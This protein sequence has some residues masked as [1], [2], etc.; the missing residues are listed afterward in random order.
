VRAQT[1]ALPIVTAGPF[2]VRA[3]TTALS[4]SQLELSA[5]VPG[6]I[7]IENEAT[8]AAKVSARMS[9]T[10][11]DVR[12]VPGTPATVHV[13]S[14][15]DSGTV[16]PITV[17]VSAADPWS[18]LAA[19]AIPPIDAHVSARNVST[20]MI[21]ALA[22]EPER[23]PGAIGRALD[24][25][26]DAV[27]ANLEGGTL[28]VNVTG[29]D[30][31]PR[32]VLE[33]GARIE[34]GLVHIDG[35]NAV[36]MRWSPDELWLQR[37]IAALLAPG[38]KLVPD[39]GSELVS[40]EAKNVVVPLPVEG[41]DLKAS[42]RASTAADVTVR[43]SGATW[44]DDALRAAHTEVAVRALETTVKLSA[45]GAFTASV[46]GE[47]HQGPSKGR[48]SAD[49]STSDAWAFA[50]GP[51]VAMP[52]VDAR[53]LADGI[54]TALVD[55]FAHQDG[56]VAKVIGDKLSVSLD[57]KGASPTSGTL[58]AEL[59][60]P[61]A[62]A[63]FS[64]H[65]ET[66]SFRASGTDGL[67]V[68]V[69]VPEA[70]V[71]EQLAGKLPEG[72]S[73]KWPQGA[74]E[75][76]FDANDLSVPVPKPGA[77]P[78][79]L[80]A[81]LESTGAHMHAQLSAVGVENAMT[82]DAKLDVGARELTFDA[83]LS[84]HAPVDVKVA[85]K[86]DPGRDARLDLAARVV[87]PF[88][89]LKGAE[90]KPID[91]T[92]TLTGLDTAALDVLAGKQGLL[93][94]L[95][96]PSLDVSLSANGAS[97]AG[98]SM[99]MN[100]KSESL[101]VKGSAQF[102]K[103]T[104]RC[105]GKDGLDVALTPRPGSLDAYAKTVL[106]AGTRLQFA[107]DA[108]PLT[109]KLHDVSI[110]L[111][112]GAAPS[113]ST[114]AAGTPT[115]A[116]AAETSMLERVSKMSLTCEATMPAIVY[117][118]ASEQPV[119]V[120]NV[121]VEARLSPTEPPYLRVNGAVEATPPGVI[122]VDV[123]ALDPLAKLADPSALDTWRAKVDVR[124][125]QVPTA[126]VD[127]LAG[128]GGLLVEALGAHVDAMVQAPEISLSKGAFVVDLKSEQDSLH[129]EGHLADRAVII[130]KQDGVLA[131]VGLGPLMS[132]R[133]VG[134]LLPTLVDVQKP[135]DAAPAMFAVDALHFPLDGDLR[136]LD[137]NVRIDLG[138]ITYG[139]GNLKSGFAGK[140]ASALG[141]SMPT[142]T[143]K[144]PAITVP[145][146][147]G[148]AGYDKLPIQIGGHEYMFSG[149]YDMV[150]DVALLSA[151][152]PVKLLGKKISAELDRVRDYVDPDITVPITIKG[153]ILNPSIGLDN[154][155]LEKVLKKAAE[156]AVG[157]GLDG[158][159]D[160]L[161]KKKKD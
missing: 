107:A 16:G 35:E 78:F 80:A 88:G 36:R 141:S 62:T 156:K 47:L 11:I 127:L 121:R 153:S 149:T 30:V 122:A 63:S 114:P 54:P 138:V 58:R 145:I 7:G 79:D 113:S 64:G 75:L 68:V 13:E 134:K 95:L 85:A 33:A 34:A 57:A 46:R 101:T 84:P 103:G 99:T 72:T 70:V 161:K 45:G 67:H 51:S 90:L 77:Q 61:R 126:I 50:G 41:K 115:P 92:L 43:V 20:V 109:L 10:R 108:G 102:D 81:L 4:K 87:E 142:G 21:G 110:P 82:R 112:S 128:Q 9:G 119:T 2:D 160:G 96:G 151:Q 116:V 111:P 53:V 44:S 38:A 98:G 49:V 56:L 120:R 158:L 125:T 8:R 154:G 129:A 152:V 5:S 55:A 105:T 93:A 124:A 71:R 97:A 100:A 26:I 132:Q 59:T 143:W 118:D 17:D 52:P 28:H 40:I 66:E 144:V 24:V 117:S 133:V 1:F 83:L 73:L 135:D 130:D 131:H 76:S 14:A 65:L 139:L 39:T 155:A 146:K 23:V 148:V 31:D 27:K 136:K 157:K 69:K 42:L 29:R 104:L 6:R 86:L 22:G 137:G 18:K 140:I 12:L 147:K 60:S 37:E 15:L 106:P 89:V 74:A 91:A 123:H 25:Q 19:G 32:F 48:L 94:G 159:L 150:T 3:I